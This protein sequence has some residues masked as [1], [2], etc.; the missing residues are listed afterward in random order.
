VS[1]ALIFSTGRKYMPYPKGTPHNH[2]GKWPQIAKMFRLFQGKT[3]IRTCMWSLPVFQCWPLIKKF[4]SVCASPRSYMGR[5]VSRKYQHSH[6]FSYD[7]SL[8]IL[9]NIW[10]TENISIV[11][12]NCDVI[13]RAQERTLVM[14]WQ[15]GTFNKTRVNEHKKLSGFTVNHSF[16]N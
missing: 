7:F 16:L 2:L 8:L 10:C 3:D 12:K 13:N 14:T 9:L 11:T 4:H 1:R 6:N 15:F 5:K